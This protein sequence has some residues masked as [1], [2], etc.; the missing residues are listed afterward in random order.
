MRLL[1]RFAPLVSLAVAL[2]GNALATP[3]AVSITAPTANKNF[4]APATITIT[5]TATPASGTTITKVDFYRGGSTLIGTASSSPWTITWNNV[6]IGNYS[7]TAKATDSI[8]GTRTSSAVAITVKTN[9]V[10]SV[11]ISSPTASTVF[12]SP[13]SITINATASDTDGTVK[14]V[15]FKS[16]STVI[17][18]DT[19]PP[20]PF[21]VVYSPTPPAS[22]T[23]FSLTGIATDNSGGTKTSSAV[24]ITVLPRPKITWSSPAN[25]ATFPPGNIA[26]STTSVT[27]TSPATVTKVE[28][29]N[30]STLIGTK[31]S[32]SPYNFTWTNVPAG[33]Y[34]LKA[35]V[36]DSKGGWTETTPVNITVIQPHQPPTVSITSPTSGSVTQAP[37]TITVNATATAFD[38]S[39]ITHVD[40]FNGTTPIGSINAPPYT[41]T[42]PNMGA[43]GYLLKAKAF[44][45]T[46]ASTD[47][48]LVYAI[49][50]GADS[51]DTTPPLA[52]AA[53]ATQLAAYGNLPLSFEE[54]LGQTDSRVKFLARGPAYQLFLTQ[55]SSV[56]ALRSPEARQAAIRMTFA[57]GNDQPVVTGLEKQ[58]S[59][60]NYMVGKDPSSWRTNVANYS[61][62]RL[63]AV[64]PGID[65][66]Y[67]A[68]QGKLEYDLLVAP[69]ANPSAVRLAFDGVDGLSI[70]DHG[71]LVLR[72]FAGSISQLKP[73][74][75]Q[76]ADGIRAAVDASYRLVDGK[77]VEFELGAYDNSRTLVIDPV[78]VY[79][80][81]ISG[82]DVSGA[83][84]IAL[85]RCG[86][87][88]ATGW[89]WAT[90][91]PTTSG[92]F[93]PVGDTFSRMGFVSKLNQAGSALL[94]STY[95]TG[96]TFD[97]SGNEVAQNTDLSSIA[98]DSTGHAYVAGSTNALDFPVTPGAL[99]T[100][101][102]QNP[103]G[104]LAKLNSNG[105]ALIYSTYMDYPALNG[106]AVDASNS[107]YVVSA[108]RAIKVAPN[109]ASTAYVYTVGGDGGAG[110]TDFASAIAVDTA[111]NAYVTGVTYS[112]NTL[113]VTP[114]A[115][116]TTFP[117]TTSS[118]TGFVAKINPAGTQ[119]VFGTYLGSRGFVSPSAIALDSSGRVYVGGRADGTISFPS[120]I[121]AGQM[122]RMDNDH[123]AN[124]YAFASRLS[125]DGSQLEYFSWIGGMYCPTENCS[126]AQTMTNGIAVDASS[127]TWITGTT[128]SN[129]IP[130]VK[131]I[132]GNFATSGGDGFA[133]K[134]N[135]VGTT[136]LFGT[137]LN[138]N[139]VGNISPI[140][141]AGSNSAGIAVDSIGSAYVTGW[142]NKLDYPTTP[143]AYQTTPA[144]SYAPNVF[145]TKINETKDVTV[146]LGVSPATGNVGSP[147]TLTATITGNAPTGTVSFFDGSTS[148]GT[149]AVS[150]TTAQ[151]ITS[152]LGGGDHTLYAA[153]SGDAHNN[154]GVSAD[155][156]YSV[157][158]STGIPTVSITGIAEGASLSTNSGGLLVNQRVTVTATAAAGNLITHVDVYL[159][160]S[161]VNFW[162]TSASSTNRLVTLPNMAPAFYFVHAIATDNFG[163]HN[164]VSPLRFVVNLAGAAL[165]SVSITAPTNGSSAPSFP[166][167]TFTASATAGSGTINNVTYYQG[168]TAIGSGT[169][170]PYTFNWANAPPGTYSVMAL[171]LDSGGARKLSA[172]ITLTVTAP[173]P[174]TVTLTSPANGASYMM[175]TT[176]PL[177]A[178][179]TPA[180]G[181]NITKVE[182]FDGAA[183]LSTITGPPPYSYSWT[184][185]T[186]GSH[187]ITAKATD[188]RNAT[189]TTPAANITVTTPPPPNVSITAPAGGSSFVTPATV[190]VTAT[191]SGVGGATIT[192]VDLYAN[193]TL[194]GSG[195]STTWNVVVPGT[196]ALTAKA[197]D[198]NNG[199]ATS[200]PVTVTI[201]GDPNEKVTFIH[202]DFAGNPIAGTDLNGVVVWKENYTPFGLR[203]VN[204]AA[205]SSSHQWFGGKPQDLESGLSYF[206]ARYYDPFLGR[207]MGID[208]VNFD[209]AALESF[210]RFNY[211][212][213]NPYRF[214]DPDG[215]F[216][217][218]L[219]ILEGSLII[220]GLYIANCPGCQ[221]SIIDGFQAAR[222]GWNA[223]FN[224]SGEG[225]EGKGEKSP[226]KGSDTPGSGE[227][228]GCIYCV[229][230][231]K[232]RSG[233]EYIG[234]SDDKE[235][236][237]RDKSDGRDRRGAET[238]DTYP[239]GDKDVRRAKEQQAI[240]DRGGVDKLDN[241]R[242]EIRP[243]KWPDFGV[244]PPGK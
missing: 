115:F 178:T 76:E 52:A 233:R 37:S 232:T 167:I 131:P 208:S 173:P 73:V 8:N 238:I 48:S 163:N 203:R 79:S 139:A 49:V 185:A 47:S 17:G 149:S 160:G 231:D 174:P 2:A 195:T 153:Y 86:E 202:N 241:R 118:S 95:I 133:I 190:T 36:T 94:Y 12:G 29:F 236:R 26:L 237:A 85:S 59:A 14:Q 155:T 125:A 152:A 61:K 156:S 18:T 230:G 212:F 41:V 184:T 122:F 45:S 40:F 15:Q 175:P 67:H 38:G 33:S 138:G 93:D 187:A 198:S 34:A 35:K 9:V 214:R 135:S 218:P 147:V 72:T 121:G 127:N 128:G 200:A 169:I 28:F 150:G 56:L 197:Y 182:F 170:S 244:T 68:T 71:A 63:S 87:A 91:F 58:P 50:D 89:T 65:A 98:L 5:A 157:V 77:H 188:D 44:D 43:G 228:T 66:V 213:N 136:M 42:L 113:P 207:F 106:V 224:E 229:K 46:G 134:L 97:N 13:A 168:S 88:Y 4:G 191:A 60:T 55:A 221:Q 102:P 141:I 23:N 74:A 30:G 103:A 162:D 210:N 137:L 83:N 242:N 109:G 145:V 161:L 166:A 39:T 82:N 234:S 111:G 204:A 21:S 101:S 54:N 24:S 22:S 142:T 154:P 226:P 177:S 227:D 240:N 205:S 196:Y 172:P 92:A 112:V 171:A 3:T 16:G 11:S 123:P 146:T 116:E 148:L 104:V 201:T 235:Q 124:I 100:T 209:P 220:G 69:G 96:T 53:K 132:N 78:L 219:G 25:N 20:S 143:G 64:Y 239:K 158:N 216:A 181:A 110:N 222:K 62:V 179:A 199:T 225:T 84:A 129:R 7:L 51:C 165:P 70:D 107:A 126:G 215:R 180:S 243:S 1:Q 99:V 140:G 183:L 193:T 159:N 57:G 105:S 194:I 27:A 130:L 211:G 144:S 117:A 189:A 186:G 119:L 32:P 192:H 19:T 108:R 10:P 31:N 223:I 81:F 80:T 206:G 75:Y 217:I 120:A 151:L 114:G 6:A 90:N 176:I 164:V